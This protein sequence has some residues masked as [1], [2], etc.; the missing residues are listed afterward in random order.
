MTKIK[1]ALKR[2]AFA[3]LVS[4][5]GC[6]TSPTPTPDP[7]PVVDYSAVCQH[8]AELG[9]PEGKEPECADAFGRFQS[10]RMADLRPSCLMVAKTA[11]EARTCGSVLC[12]GAR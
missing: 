10:G 4:L 1:H 8:L 2:A 7:V 3:L 11:T 12:E 6:G 9:C 5:V